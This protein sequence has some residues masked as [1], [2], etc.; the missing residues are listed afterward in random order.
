MGANCVTSSGSY[1]VLSL[2]LSVGISSAEAIDGA[3]GDFEVGDLYRIEDGILVID[4]SPEVGFGLNFAGVGDNLSTAGTEDDGPNANLAVLQAENVSSDSGTTSASLS[5]IESGAYGDALSS[6]HIGW[7]SWDP[8]ADDKGRHAEYGRRV[9]DLVGVF[10]IEME[11]KLGSNLSAC[12]GTA[13]WMP[14]L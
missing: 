10:S 9:T 13:E 7:A 12:P 11:I 3:G 6:S 1:L 8:K 14:C 2:L 4:W 5:L